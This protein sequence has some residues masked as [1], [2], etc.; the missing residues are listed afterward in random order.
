MP[1]VPI[2]KSR[3]TAKVREQL[4]NG[5][6]RGVNPRKLN[7]NEIHVLEQKAAPIQ[8][9]MAEARHERSAARINSHNT[10]EAESTRV[11][12][13]NEGQL[14]RQALQPIAALVTGEGDDVD[15]RVRAKRNQIALLRAGVREDLAV[16]KREREQAKADAS[17]HT[18]CDC[19][20][21]QQN[22]PGR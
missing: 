4:K 14:T 2:K 3:A 21:R 9:E 12:V 22:P 20:R 11:V 7:A 5:K 1:G 15:D 6:T 19:I 13:R 17:S 10:Q 18:Q 8:E 16:K